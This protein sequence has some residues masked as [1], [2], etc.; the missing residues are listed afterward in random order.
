[1]TDL[2]HHTSR[3]ITRFSIIGQHVR[4]CESI[5]GISRETRDV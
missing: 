4:M 2:A 1:M 5:M 3:I